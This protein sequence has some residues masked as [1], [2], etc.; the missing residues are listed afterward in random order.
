ML[1]F[2]HLTDT[3]LV[4]PG[5]ALYGNDPAQRLQQAIDSINREHADAAFVV[6]TGDLAHRGEPE[7]YAELRERLSTLNTPVHLLVGNHD[8][9]GHFLEAFTQT[10]TTDDGFV[11]YAYT[12][13]GFRHIALD[14]NEPGVSWG[15]FCERRARWL[16]D[17][18]SAGE[19][20]PV[21]LFIHHPPFGVGI[22]PMDRISLL[23]AGPLREALVPHAKRIRHLFF[24][25][26]HRPLAGSWMGIPTSTIR[27]TNH[28][29]ALQ[30]YEGERVPG[31]MEPPQYAVVLA[32]D[33]ST[34]VHFHDFADRSDRFA[35]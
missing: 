28:Q 13:S 22:P 21:H 26:L 5:H 7:A 31:S 30:L 4:T 10:P 20:L 8:D 2:I 3:H 25:H 12:A 33:E 27:G 15:V 9:R 32:N 11:Q 29:V 34:I 18:L 1:K 16:A 23:D 6:V 17:E 14:S 24:G 19:P 35:L